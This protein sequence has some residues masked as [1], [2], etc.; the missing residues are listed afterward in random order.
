M[1]WL[2]IIAIVVGEVLLSL[3]MLFTG[4]WTIKLSWGNLF[5][6]IFCTIV[7]IVIV[8]NSNLFD[9]GF[10]SYVHLKII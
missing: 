1:Y 2:A 8:N 3:Y 9:A 4:K 5:L 6:Q 10:I 7:F